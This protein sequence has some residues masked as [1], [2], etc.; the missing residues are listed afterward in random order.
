MVPL[1]YLRAESTNKISQ[2]GK[3]APVQIVGRV[4]D[5]YGRAGNAALVCSSGKDRPGASRI[6][7][8]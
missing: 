3:V 2:N 7:K 6:G 1:N 5:L 8:I 4:I